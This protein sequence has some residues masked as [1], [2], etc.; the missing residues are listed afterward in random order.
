L[1]EKPSIP[2]IPEVKKVNGN[3]EEANKTEFIILTSPLNMRTQ[4]ADIS[5]TYLYKGERIWGLDQ[6]VDEIQGHWDKYALEV[7]SGWKVEL[8]SGLFLKWTIRR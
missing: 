5:K 2:F 8:C 6:V 4:H 1:Y 3:G 7:R